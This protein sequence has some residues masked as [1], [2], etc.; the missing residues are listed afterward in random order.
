MRNQEDLAKKVEKGTTEN[1]SKEKD[2][3]SSN[4]VD[5][6]AFD[7]QKVINMDEPIKKTYSDCFTVC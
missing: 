4:K 1:D 2:E 7:S 5:E 3:D 6:S